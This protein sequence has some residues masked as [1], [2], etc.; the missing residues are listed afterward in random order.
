MLDT[1]E[2]KIQWQR[3]EDALLAMSV[4]ST[5]I[6]LYCTWSYFEDKSCGESCRLPLQGLRETREVHLKVSEA[7][8]DIIG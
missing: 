5:D 4:D 8:L 2:Q 3:E 6:I 1:V 7:S